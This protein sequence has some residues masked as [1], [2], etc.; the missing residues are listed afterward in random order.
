VIGRIAETYRRRRQAYLRSE[1]Y[2]FGRIRRA[3]RHRDAR[4]A[5]FALLDWV[6]H[7]DAASPN[8]GLDAFKTIA[9]DP[10]LDR[11]LGALETELFADRGDVPRWS[12]RQ[13][14]HRVSVARRRLRPRQEYHERARLPQHLNPAEAS[15]A[16][17]HAGRKPA[18]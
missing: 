4:T 2:A 6:P 10:A 9:C 8:S 1:A 11:Q 15:N 13:L 14:L 7:L 16:P 5:Y 12:P 3:V 17:A 18:R